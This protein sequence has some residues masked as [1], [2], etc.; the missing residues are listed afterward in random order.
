MSWWWWRRKRYYNDGCAPSWKRVQGRW[1]DQDRLFASLQPAIWRLGHIEFTPTT[2]ATPR[3]F[4]TTAVYEFA[5][6][7]CFM[8]YFDVGSAAISERERIWY[9]PIVEPDVRGMKHSLVLRVSE[10][11]FE[12]VR[13]VLRVINYP[14]H[15]PTHSLWVEEKVIDD[16]RRV[17]LIL[18]ADEDA[19][20]LCLLVFA[21][22]QNLLIGQCYNQYTKNP[23]V[24]WS[25][26]NHAAYRQ[27]DN[28]LDCWAKGK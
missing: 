14:T 27:Q 12:A 10:W 22:P 24:Y 16:G 15:S 3:S 6:S 28:K 23:R 19:N 17:D 20:T 25:S 8:P 21:V 11:V 5:P 7:G 26:I 9:N 1:E 4:I 13:H 2:K 18:R